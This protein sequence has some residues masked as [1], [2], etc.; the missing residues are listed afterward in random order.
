[1]LRPLVVEQRAA[2]RHVHDVLQRLERLAAMPHQQLGLLARD[3]QPRTVVGLVNVN[4]RR[5][6]QRRDESIQEID[7][8]LG[9]HR[10]FAF[11]V[12]RSNF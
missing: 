9:G 3:V 10:M 6:S 5:N 2:E 11:S 4:G 12:R 1:M 7:N 8:R